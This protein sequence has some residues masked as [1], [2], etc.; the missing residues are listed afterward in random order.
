MSPNSYPGPAQLRGCVVG[1]ATGALA[2]AAH[3]AAGG[4]YP[5]STGAAFLLLTALVTGWAS[6][7][8]G[9]GMRSAFAHRAAAPVVAVLGPLAAGQFAG[10]WALTGLTGHHAGA[11]TAIG[12]SLSGGP[13]GAAMFAA[14]LL[15]VLLCALVIVAAE[16]LYRAASAVVRALLTPVRDTRGALL[17]MAAGHAAAPRYRTPNGA[18]GPRAPPAPAHLDASH[19]F[20]EKVITP[21]PTGFP[22]SCAAA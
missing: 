1:V 16:R 11:D 20:G 9:P 22:R 8:V 7:S 12:E 4:G 17:G 19:T 2:V 21:C 3:G 13:F 5:T 10:H 15:A 14:H 6:G 18:S